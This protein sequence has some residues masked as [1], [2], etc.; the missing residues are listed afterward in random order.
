[1]TSPTTT[2]VTVDPQRDALARALLDVVCHP[3]ARIADELDFWLGLLSGTAG[4]LYA[5]C[6]TGHFHHQDFIGSADEVAALAAL[7]QKSANIAR[8]LASGLREVGQ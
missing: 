4:Y 3:Q 6:D 2:T 7:L 8:V 5:T 1:M